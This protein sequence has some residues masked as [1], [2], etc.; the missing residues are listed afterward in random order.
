MRLLAVSALTML[1]VFETPPAHAVSPPA[2]DDK[3]LPKPAR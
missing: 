2:V 1:P 3:W